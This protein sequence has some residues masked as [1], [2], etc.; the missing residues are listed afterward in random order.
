MHDRVLAVLGG[1]A[2]DVASGIRRRAS[3]EGLA[4]NART[5][6]DK[7][8]GYLTSHARYLDY[9]TALASGWPI[10]TGI[11][12]GACRH[13]VKDRMD[14]T[15]ARWSLAGAEAVLWLRALRA[16]GDFAQYWTFH[17]SRELDQVHRSR[18]ADGIIPMAA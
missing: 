16:N 10:A 13:I 15:G 14:L 6:A 1:A 2:R 18:Y 3:T 9:P 4:G 17:L 8:A 11:I 7:C 5:G 12:E